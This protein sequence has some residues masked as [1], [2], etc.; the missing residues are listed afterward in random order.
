MKRG[1]GRRKRDR[2]TLG[3]AI[4]ATLGLFLSYTTACDTK[5]P[6]A[7]TPTSEQPSSVVHSA[8]NPALPADTP[9]PPTSNPGPMRAD[10]NDSCGAILTNTAGGAPHS[11]FVRYTVPGDNSQTYLDPEDEYSVLPGKK[12]TV[13]PAQEVFE[14]DYQW[15]EGQCRFDKNIQCDFTAGQGE[16]LAGK[17]THVTLN[18]PR[19]EGC[20]EDDTTTVYGDWGE[21]DLA[22]NASNETDGYCF[23]CQPY[24]VFDCQENVIDRGVNQ[25][26]VDCPGCQ[27]T[28]GASF[29]HGSYDATPL[30]AAASVSDSGE[31]VLR[32]SAS[33]TFDECNANTPDFWKDTDT[34]TLECGEEDSLAV[35]YN[36]GTHNDEWWREVL[37]RN[38]SVWDQTDC[39]RNP[40]NDD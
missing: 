30:T 36:W 21:C 9:A 38:G 19:C 11:V 3:I 13:P 25:R 33:N 24:T 7:P 10:V 12:A 23:E 15:E 26:Q 8:A 40:F 17:F 27:D 14:K 29:S 31:W 39:H 1:F 28:P 4:A 16:H 35:S 20:D 34:A 32:I 6:S 2:W 22:V 37:F 18:N 5:G